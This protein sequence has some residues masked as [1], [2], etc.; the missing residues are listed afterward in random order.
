MS[1]ETLVTNVCFAG[2]S[3]EC[4]KKWAKENYLLLWVHVIPASCGWH[5]HHSL[6]FNTHILT[7]QGSQDQRM[8]TSLIS[9]KGGNIF[10]TAD[11][12]NPKIPPVGMDV[13]LGLL[14]EEDIH[15]T[16]QEQQLITVWYVLHVQTQHRKLLPSP[17]MHQL[18]KIKSLNW[19]NSI[20]NVV[21]WAEWMWNKLGKQQ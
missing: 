6:E 15:G 12:S 4:L 8:C 11:I 21:K 2:E 9:T 3:Q 5:E 20:T 10:N 19:D 7:K 13:I 18:S 16:V 14:T 1:Y 17:R